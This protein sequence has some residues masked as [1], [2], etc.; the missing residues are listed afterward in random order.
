MQGSCRTDN[1]SVA[2]REAKNH[3]GL[4]ETTH[5][6]WVLLRIAIL[7]NVILRKVIDQLR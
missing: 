2:A 5:I 7:R 3:R 6:R 4:R 1:T